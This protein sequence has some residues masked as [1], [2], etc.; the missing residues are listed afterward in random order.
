MDV[1]TVHQQLLADYEAFTS[2]FAKIH[3]PE[4]RKHV[5]Q[6]E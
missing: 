3:D 2:G 6:R 5:E 4:I 1:F